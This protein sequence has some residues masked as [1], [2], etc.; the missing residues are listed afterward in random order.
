[1]NLAV[2]GSGSRGNA[3]IVSTGRTMILIDAGFGRAAL[4][5]RAARAGFDLGRL[6][7]VVVTHE[8]TDHATGA[9]ALTSHAACPLY[10]TPGT[11]RALASSLDGTDARPLQS[12]GTAIGRIQV[13][14]AR[15][16][17][18]AAEPVALRLT[19]TGSGF[20]LGIAYDLGSAT[21][22][23]LRL[24]TGVHC[25]MLEANHDEGMLRSGPYPA[26]VRQRIAG[27]RGHLSNWQAA[28]AA[29]DL[30]HD[31][32]ETVVLMHLSQ[33]CNRPEIAREAV[34]AALHARGYRGQLFVA[35]Q[36]TALPVPVRTQQLALG[37]F[38]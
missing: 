6:S 21:P 2:L 26:S 4:T 8:H 14:T 35:K 10:A 20:R 18:D 24:L 11:L 3:V 15:T 22:R 30:Y 23:L 38:E 9:V 1:V 29:A 27:A 32:L 36:D 37:L 25:L 33:R 5:E 13:H 17:H 19:D 12:D 7:A 31:E 28:R 34:G 16:R